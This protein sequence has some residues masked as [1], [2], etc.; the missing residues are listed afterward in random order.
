MLHG[1]TGSASFP[2]RNGSSLAAWSVCGPAFRRADSQVRNGRHK[3]KSVARLAHLYST[4]P[5]SP[6]LPSC[7]TSWD[8]TSMNPPPPYTGKY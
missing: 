4:R 6:T 3:A 7:A 2:V 8:R 5:E 1:L